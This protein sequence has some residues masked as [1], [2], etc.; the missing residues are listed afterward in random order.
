MHADQKVARAVHLDDLTVA[1]RGSR[2]SPQHVALNGVS[3]EIPYGTVLGVLG[4]TGSGKSTL[5]RVLAGETRGRGRS[6]V[7]PKIIGGD[8]I[9]VGRRI[10]SMRKRSANRLTFDVGY[11]AQDAATTLRRD[12]VVADLV[13]E[14]IYCRDRAYD[15]HEANGRVAALLDAVHLPLGTLTRY[16]Y[17][18]SSGQRQ[19]VSLARALVLGPKLL[20]ADEPTA[21]V[22]LTVRDA[23][24]DVVAEL[25]RAGDF[26]AV[27]ISH[28]LAVLRQLT[29]QIVVLHGGNVVALGSIDDVLAESHH[30][31]VVG[32]SHALDDFRAR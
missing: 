2:S 7:R 4:D 27:V 16:P 14:P 31:F 3:V 8:A 26:S 15:S 22:D 1:Y 20:V 21:G 10:R 23:V 12:S 5:A 9:V 32:L 6:V 24:V 17:E 18:L 13:A 11:L 19:R 29:D 30:P 25:K 28:D